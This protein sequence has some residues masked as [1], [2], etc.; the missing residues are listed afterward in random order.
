VAIFLLGVA[1]RLVPRPKAM[2]AYKKAPCPL[3]FGVAGFLVTFGHF[4]IVYQGA[5]E[6]KYPFLVAMILLAV[7]DLFLLWLIWYWSGRGAAWTD[8][9]RITLINGAL[10]FF[11]VLGPLTVGSQ[12]PV[13]YFS[14]PAFTAT[15]SPIFRG[16]GSVCIHQALLSFCINFLRN[17]TTLGAM[18][19]RQ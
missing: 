18:I 7:F 15:H 4:F 14:N 19:A 3:W 8:R 5:D 13:M 17:L 9:H 16:L 10:T 2:T 11:L 6:G 1:A 12:Y